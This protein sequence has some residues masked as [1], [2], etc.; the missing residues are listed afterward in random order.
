[1]SVA[2]TYFPEQT[3]LP[4]RR[5][6]QETI[7]AMAMTTGKDYIQTGSNV[8]VTIGDKQLLTLFAG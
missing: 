1:M 7:A 4:F 2:E 6:H 8:V 3:Y 5:L